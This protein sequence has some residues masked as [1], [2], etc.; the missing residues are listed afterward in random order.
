MEP[1]INQT[2][3]PTPKNKTW[4]WIVLIILFTLLTSGGV[5][6]WQSLETRKIVKNNEENATNT[7]NE[8][9]TK[10]NEANDKITALE[11]NL[12]TEK[13]KNNQLVD[14]KN[15]IDNIQFQYP[16][17]WNI[18]AEKDGWLFSGT[19]GHFWLKINDNNSKFNANNIKEDYYKND[20]YGYQYEDSFVDIAG[21]QSYKQA[22]YD[23]GVI[24]RYFIPKNNKI[25]NLDFEFNFTTPNEEKNKEIKD[26]INKIISSVKIN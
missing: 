3:T 23:L 5:Y 17:L 7:N 14:Y 13:E 16:G 10:L 9:Q 4:L 22:R 15:F 2:P 6:Y 11:N 21:V 12:N 1:I 18:S 8:W 25:F 19:D 26:L 24:E 20:T